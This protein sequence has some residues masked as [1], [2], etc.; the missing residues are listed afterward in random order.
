MVRSILVVCIGN[1]CRSP[2]AAS[3]LERALPACQVSSAG[4]APPVGAPA[5]PRAAKALAR[6]GCN[7]KDHRARAVDSTLVVAADLILVM[8]DKQR[9][10]LEQIYPQAQGKTYRLCE[11]IHSDV[12]DPYGCSQG[13]FDIVLELIKQGIASWAA[14]LGVVVPADSH[15]EAS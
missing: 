2:M 11:A 15:G 10:E 6:E 3:L 13:M 8:D 14:Q 7:L 12:P 4:L 9:A 5:D 1:V